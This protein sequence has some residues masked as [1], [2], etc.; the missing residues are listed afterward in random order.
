MLFFLGC[1]QEKPAYIISVSNELQVDRKGET[2]AVQKSDLGNITCELFSR[3]SIQDAETG[4]YLLSQGMDEDMD[5][6]LDYLL[7]QPA[8]KAGETRT[9]NVVSDVDASLLPGREISTYSRFVPERT[10]DYAWENDLV[11]FRTYG[12]TAEQMVVD[13][14]PGGTLSSG[15]D[16]S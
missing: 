2:V 6:E 9:Y 11:A 5:G 3:F 10:D 7:F 12:P 15:I 16:C 8:L 14:T 4:E 1:N 13:K